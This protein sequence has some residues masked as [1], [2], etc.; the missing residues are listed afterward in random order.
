MTSVK[1]FDYE[2][3]VANAK[4]AE[5]EFSKLDQDQ[6]DK[7]FLRMA[8]AADRAR[9]PLAQLACTETGMGLVEDKV[10]VLH[11]LW[12]FVDSYFH[13]TGSGRSKKNDKVSQRTIY[14]ISIKILI[15]IFSISTYCIQHGPGP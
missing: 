14:L 8:H 4:K 15:D 12:M 7:I 3:M 2:A 6:V 10:R 5:L 13:F 11:A 9:V 1:S